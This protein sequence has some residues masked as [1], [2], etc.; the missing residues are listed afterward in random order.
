MLYTCWL[1]A[2]FHSWHRTVSANSPLHP[3]PLWNALL[4]SY[5][6][7][8]HLPL[9][10]LQKQWFQGNQSSTNC[11][12]HHP[13]PW[14]SLPRQESM[15][16]AAHPPCRAEHLESGVQALLRGCS[17]VWLSLLS[18]DPPREPANSVESTLVPP[19]AFLELACPSSADS[20]GAA[21]C[22]GLSC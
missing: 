5:R 6:T 4:T 19:A 10:D 13:L 3:P 9:P 22:L 18:P 2:K 21:I 1:I 7:Q 17:L 14:E 16:L 8:Y 15:C 12:S 20:G 11:L